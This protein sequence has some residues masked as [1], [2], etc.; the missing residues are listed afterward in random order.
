MSDV[1]ALSAI[2]LI[3]E[4]LPQAWANPDNLEARSQTL[5]GA[6]QAGIAFSNSSVA[7]VHGM[8]RPV[9]ANFHV[10]HGVSNARPAGHSPCGFP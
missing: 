5:L 7:L 3:S 9:G 2:G 10:P 1:M 8:S 4:Y 6:L